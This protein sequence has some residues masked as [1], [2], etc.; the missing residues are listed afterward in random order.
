[1]ARRMASPAR[2]FAVYQCLSQQAETVRDFQLAA[3]D[4]VSGTVQMLLAGQRD[5]FLE[6]WVEEMQELCDVLE[7]RHDD[8]YIVEATQC[9][10]WASL[11]AVSGDADW[12]AI[13]F[14]ALRR[15]VPATRI[16]G[17]DQLMAA[18]RRLAELGPERAKPS[19]LFMLWLVADGLYRGRTAAGR[20]WS[21]EEIME[22]DL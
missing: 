14:D 6:R 12:V 4:Q 19:K 2:I 16:D 5:R 20:Q 9:F 1:M 22:Y 8:P 21:L 13:D 18:C 7:G 10:Y 11:F 15:Q 17:T 3:G